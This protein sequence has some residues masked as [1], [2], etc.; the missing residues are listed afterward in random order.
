MVYSTVLAAVPTTLAWGPNVAAVM[1][2]CNIIAIAF[3]KFTIKYP[4]AGP[5]MPSANLFGGFGLPAVIGT[6]CFGHIL[7][8]G[9][10]LGLANMG[11]L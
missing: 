3:G 1:I 6:T 4:S 2:I 5:A 7:G 11:A 9:V 8:A 10:I